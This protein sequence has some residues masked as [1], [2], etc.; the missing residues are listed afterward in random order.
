MPAEGTRRP[1]SSIRWTA[2]ALAIVGVGVAFAGEHL[3]QYDEFDVQIVDW[4]PAERLVFALTFALFAVA[5]V[6]AAVIA[7][8]KRSRIAATA[9]A[10]YGTL[11]IVN[12]AAYATATV[13]ADG[14]S[15]ATGIWVAL[16]GDLITAVG[17]WLMVLGVRR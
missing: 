9:L 1:G 4:W 13:I 12:S 14:L 11:A 10:T 5:A 16:A 7:A 8:A 3:H 6:G 2:A 17:A 15:P